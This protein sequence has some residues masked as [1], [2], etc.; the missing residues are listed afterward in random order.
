MQSKQLGNENKAILSS[1]KIGEVR[2]QQ[3]S[4]PY[5]QKW[6]AQSN[7]VPPR[8]VLT[9]D[10][11]K[12]KTR[13]FAFNQ[14]NCAISI[15]TVVGSFTSINSWGKLSGLLISTSLFLWTLY[16]FSILKYIHKNK[17][18]DDYFFYI[19]ILCFVASI[20]CFILL[21]I[22]L[23]VPNLTANLNQMEG[24]LLPSSNIATKSMI[25]FKS[26]STIYF[27]VSLMFV[28]PVYLFHVDPSHA[29]TVLLI[30]LATHLIPSFLFY[31][32]H[33]RNEDFKLDERNLQINL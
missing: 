24:P 31:V 12:L 26:L 25:S 27:L 6:V 18:F 28:F 32:A 14:R 23:I 1:F 22:V 33:L 29:I 17:Q 4:P 30:I 21:T 19:N 3:A 10:I 2:T 20:T 13:L 8:K 9:A 15:S 16:S 7:R 5:K 11:S